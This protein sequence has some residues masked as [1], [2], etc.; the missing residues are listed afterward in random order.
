[1]MDALA[2]S[3]LQI[4]THLTAKVATDPQLHDSICSIS[5]SCLCSLQRDTQESVV[6]IY[7]P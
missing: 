7:Q 4:Y 6:L 1:M 5:N 3:P 2:M